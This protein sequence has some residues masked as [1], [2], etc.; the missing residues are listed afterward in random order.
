MYLLRPY[1]K[2]V[3]IIGLDGDAHQKPFGEVLDCVPWAYNV[4]KLCA[5]CNPCCDGTEAPYTKKLK[6]DDQQVDVGGA[7]K[8]QAV[9]LKHL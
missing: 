5:L 4:S 7:E 9:C 2:D 3:L 1:K 6:N 8:Y